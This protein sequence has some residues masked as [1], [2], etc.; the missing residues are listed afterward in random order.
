MKPAKRLGEPTPG[1]FQELF[2]RKE[3]LEAEGKTIYDLSVG[4]PVFPPDEHVIETLS[5]E[6]ARPEEYG[7]AMADLPVLTSAIQDYYQERFGVPLSATEITAVHGTQ[8]GMAHIFLAICDPGDLVLVPNPGYPIFSDGPL[9]CGATVWPYPLYEEKDYVLDF[10]DIPEDIAQKAKVIIV[11]Y[12][13]NPVCASADA[14]FYERLIHFAKQYDIIVIHD[15]AY[16]DLAFGET[17]YP[18]FLSFEGAKEV[19]VEFYS[20]SKTYNYTGA[21]LSFLLGN[22]MI[23]QSLKV[24]RSK[25][26]YGIFRPIQK[27]GA[28]A[29]TGSQEPVKVRCR[30]YEQQARYLA[31]Q[32]RSIGW[33]VRDSQGTMFLWTGLPFGYTDSNQFVLDLMEETGVIVTP[34]SAFGSLGEGHVRFALRCSDAT[35]QE[36]ADAIRKWAVRIEELGKK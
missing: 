12:P 16:A 9:L 8:E 34:G 6:A 11:S 5:A 10:Q 17:P 33:P 24:V 23:V 20:L 3:A 22:E 18:S 27:A 13:L 2:L 19:G 35:L 36:V 31:D 4:T 1:I 32:L 28:A 30:I 21:R 29:L 25:M 15:A 26:D 7:Y 14:D